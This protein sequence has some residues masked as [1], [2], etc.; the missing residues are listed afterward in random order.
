MNFPLSSLFAVA[1]LLAGTVSV[2]ADTAPVD[3]DQSIAPILAKHCLQCHRGADSEGGLD[4]SRKETSFAGGESGSAI[5]RGLIDESLLWKRIEA[6]EMPPEKPLLSDE[7]ELIRRWIEAG[8]VW[9]TNPIDPFAS[10][11]DERAGRDWW[12]FQPIER[13]QIKEIGSDAIDRLIH[14]K[15]EAAGLAPSAPASPREL[16]RRMSFDLLG[17]PPTPEQVDA[18]EKAMKKDRGSAVANLIDSLLASH[19]Y[20]ERWARHWLD[21]ARFGESHG[22]ER[23]S[24]RE[25][26]WHYR[27]WVIDQLNE[28]VP[29]DQ[30][31]RSQLAGDVLNPENPSA[32][33]PTGF[34]VA[35]A[36]DEVGQSQQSAAMKAVVRQDELE[37]YVGTVGQAFLGLTINCARCHD[38]KFDPISQREYYRMAA[39]FAGVR[40]RSYSVFDPQAEQRRG[41]LDPEIKQLQKRVRSLEET[42]HLRMIAKDPDV[43]LAPRKIVATARWEFEDGLLD[44]IGNAH[45]IA[46]RGA[47]ISDGNLILDQKSGFARTANQP[48]ELKEKT[49]EA[50]VRLSDLSQRGGSL[51]TIHKTD[52]KTFDAVVFGERKPRE[53][54]AGSEF[55]RRTRDFGGK[56]EDMADRQFTHIA[57]TWAADGTISGYRNGEPYGEPYQVDQLVTFEPGQWFIQFGLR[58]GTPAPSRQLHGQLDTAQVYDRALSAEEIRQSF[59]YEASRIKRADIL[60]AMTDEEESQHTQLKERI[61]ECKTQ[62]EQ[63][64]PYSIYAVNPQPPA[65]THLLARGNPN[66]K[67]DELAAGGIEAIVGPEA[68]FGL[69]LDASDRQRRIALA[70]WITSDANPL[71]AR[72][73]VNRIWHHHFGTG[74]VDS[75]N[76][77]GFSGGRPSHE[78][79]LDWLAAELIESGFRLKHIHRLILGSRTYQQSSRSR[80]SAAGLDSD[81]RLLWRYTA[82]RLD[83]ESLRDNI[84]FV[85]GQINLQRGG[86]PYQD[87]ETHVHNSQF[88]KMVDRDHPDVYRRTI[89]RTWI[90]SGRSQLLD[91]FDCP[92]PS[93]TAPKRTVT[94]TPLQAL[95][96]MNSSFTLRMADRFAERV[97]REAGD[98]PREQADRV[99]RLAYGRRIDREEATSATRFINDYSLSAFCRAVLNSNEFIHVD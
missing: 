81:N 37:D 3:F 26:S 29:Y 54:M 60:A 32:A 16:L 24:L 58:V 31:V 84:L 36:W 34:L 83:A 80:K 14:D 41:E 61:A 13:P 79:L 25:D 21:I 59:Q 63:L 38:H 50:W 35:G 96:M 65:K 28:D 62:R 15:L 85:S 45:A 86:P 7:R 75:P 99:Y 87:F 22:F 71:F 17:L 19:H 53:W 52:D 78:E 97:S 74:I 72:V 88:Y 57:V 23:D 46:H 69:E 66:S 67:G 4:L 33:I 18:F 47:K 92:D 10:S 64:E 70:N 56:E 77:F 12:S 94:T 48:F 73:I 8:A 2:D 82:R 39:A 76:D 95:T 68:E 55:F 1:A 6:G 49:L 93:T 40:P 30:F 89:Y 98:D 20:G 43:A 51:I 42:V 91:V 9:G 27:D 11:N 44:R 5:K 90:R